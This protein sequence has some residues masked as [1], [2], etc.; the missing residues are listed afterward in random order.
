MFPTPRIATEKIPECK[1]HIERGDHLRLYRFSPSD[2]QELA[3]VF[4]GPNPE[5]GEDLVIFDEAPEG[6]PPRD[7]PPQPAVFAPDLE[8]E[9]IAEIATKLRQKAGLPKE[10]TGLVA[11]LRAQ[12]KRSTK[13][14]TSRSKSRSR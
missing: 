10:P 2:Y 8:P 14:A 6:V 11:D 7:L 13:K 9:E 4:N 12:T 1:P 5:T 3:A